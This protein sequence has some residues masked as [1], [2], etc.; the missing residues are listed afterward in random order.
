MAAR[1]RGIAW[2]LTALI[3]IAVL[4]AIPVRDPGST[5]ERVAREDTVIFDLDRS[6]K[7][8]R[9]FNWFTPGVKRLHGAHQA[10]WEPMFVL[11]Y[12]TGELEPWLGLS[13]VSNNT[14]DL[15]TPAGCSMVRWR[16]FRC[17]RRRLHG[18]HG[19]PVRRR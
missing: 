9:N 13:I 15:W 2:G 16:K 8:P 14:H 4:V 19:E 18:Q 6:I 3:G 1:S 7:N 5:E 11:S 17:G 10:M 12:A